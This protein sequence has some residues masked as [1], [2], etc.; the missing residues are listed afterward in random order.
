MMFRQ[1]GLSQET[2]LTLC[3]S[4][5]ILAVNDMLPSCVAL[6]AFCIPINVCV[7]LNYAAASNLIQ[8]Q[9]VTCVS[10]SLTHAQLPA[11]TGFACPLY[12]FDNYNGYAPQL[13]TY[14]V[15]ICCFPKYVIRKKRLL[16]TR[17]DKSSAS[18]T[19]PSAFFTR[20]RQPIVPLQMTRSTP[21]LARSFAPL[22]VASCTAPPACQSRI[23]QVVAPGCTSTISTEA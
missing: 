14:L 18:A 11:I 20:T 17:F 4:V 22:A 5:F 16:P 10:V 9:M 23:Q 19:G 6:K 21:A 3:Q 15:I 13:T 7:H 8:F 12:V 2:D 1:K